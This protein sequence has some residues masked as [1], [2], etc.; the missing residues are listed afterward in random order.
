M[1]ERL[2][3]A[4]I[5]EA[6][7]RLIDDDGLDGLTVRR[8]AALLGVQNPALYWHF[9]DKRELLDAVA[10][11][12]VRSA[13][14]GPPR[15]GESWQEWLLRRGRGYRD[16]LRA[17]R[18]GARIVANARM[19]PETVRQ[20]NGELGAMVAQGFTPVLALRTITTIA[21]YVNGFV[22]QEQTARLDEADRQVAALDRILDDDPAGPLHHAV[23]DGGDPFEP[24]TFDHGLRVI[25]EGTAQV[26][27]SAPAAAPTGAT[28]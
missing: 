18:D 10:D 28:G 7:I 20:L 12:I 23:R 15:E 4:V 9:R 16:A 1:R 8:C 21:Q 5:V 2:T 24:T 27:G 17:H 25:V 3:R 14:M 22:L 19:G 26:L 11:E 13:G 6:A